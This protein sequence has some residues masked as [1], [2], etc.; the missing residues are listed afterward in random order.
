MPQ[1]HYTQISLEE[2][3]IIQNRLENGESIRCIARSI[4]RN[5][6]SVSREI[7]RNGEHRKSRVNIPHELYLDSRHFRGTDKVDKIRS[8]KKSYRKR[9]HEFNKSR[10]KA[11]DAE[12]KAL[13]RTKE[14]PLALTTVSYGETRKYVLEKLTLRWSPEQISGRLSLEGKLPYVSA[15]AIYAFIYLPENKRLIKH[16]RRRGKPKRIKNNVVFN[17]TKNKRNISERPSIINTL[18]RFGDLEGDTIFGKDTKDRILTHVERKSGLLSASLV[19]GYNGQNISKQTILDT[20][21]V[22]G[23]TTSITYDNG[24]EFTMWQQTEK[25]LHTTIYFA[26]PYHS[27]ERGRNENTNGLIRDFFPKGT[28][29]KKV[30]K[31]DILEV[32]SLI[33]NRP[34]KRLQWLTPLEYYKSQCCT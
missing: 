16:L 21:R 9:L 5:P 27:W 7:I 2:R 34:R 8:R 3:I 32:E 11:K 19:R 20:R 1:H 33:N 22:F 6:S 10:Y 23:K 24:S 26:N 12:I 25:Q 18:G 17:K 28:D 13:R 29:F 30:T 31:A 15:R 14:Q 4:N